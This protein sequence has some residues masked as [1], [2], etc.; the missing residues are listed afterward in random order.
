MVP[1]NNIPQNL[2]VPLFYAETDNSQANTGQQTQRALIIGQITPDGK[3]TPNVPLI[4]QG[5]GDAISQG[6]AGSMLA[7]MTAAYL[8][9]DNFG[10]V[11]YLPLADAGASQAASG[12]ISVTT[13]PNANGA[14]SLYIAGALVSVAVSSFDEAADVATAIAA[15]ITGTTSLPVT[16]TVDGVTPTK[17]NLTAKNKGLAGNDI[18]LRLNYR[19][20]AAGE[21]T[22]AG[23]ALA[24]VAMSGG[25]VNPTLATALA[26]LGDRTFDFIASGYN[27]TASLDAL[28]TFLDDQTG[29]WSWTSQTYGHVFGGLRGTLA[30]A[31]TFLTARNNQHEAIFPFNDS[32]TPYW[33]LAADF[34]ATAAVS[35]RVDPGRP[36]QTLP[37][38]TFLAPP[39]ESRFTLTERN[40][41]LFDGGSTFTVDDDGTVR[42]ENIITT[43]QKN[44][45]GDPD[46]SYLEVE[47]LFQIM[48]VL[49][50][51]KSL[52]TSKYG[53]V[54][55]ADD[56][57]RFA[58]GSAIVTPSIIKADL[59]AEYQTLESNGYVQNS[60]V[61]AQQI[62]VERNA[63]NRNRIDVLLPPDL[64]N[65]LRVFAV[66]A[67]FRQ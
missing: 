43:Y 15:A 6:G 24:I 1:F 20:D 65:Q 40:T 39:E 63:L 26:N 18:D 21:Q 48:F 59:I 34:A 54:K 4:C 25:T 7:L 36:L 46:D 32:P 47:T 28:K 8:A 51:F 29:R 23:L 31:T 53:R 45:F 27:D 49:R 22:P 61:F 2:R 56:G 58:P 64:I 5:K 66:L 67:Q 55:L 50:A 35:L 3:A 9:A 13:P 17:V 11:W 10:E 62:V 37:L 57:T 52:V 30:S 42:L 38:S 41:L 60:D 33:V 16:A 12:S 14:L 44:A 19:G